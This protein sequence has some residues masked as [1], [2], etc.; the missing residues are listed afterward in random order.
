MSFTKD[1]LALQAYIEEQNEQARRNAEKDGRTLIGQTVS[2]P[3]HWAG[4]GIHTID[5]YRHNE[6][7]SFYSDMYKDLNGFRPRWMKFDTMTADEIW[8]EVDQLQKQV[9]ADREYEKEQERQ[10]EKDA[11]ARKEANKYQPNL[12]F[13]GLKDMLK[14][15]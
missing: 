3:E 14:G 12:A 13:S 5:Q 7:A 6:A 9:D 4:Y 10:A 11:Q 1:Q 2:D 15:P 8:Y